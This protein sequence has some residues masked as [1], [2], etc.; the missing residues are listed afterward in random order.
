MRSDL[1]ILGVFLLLGGCVAYEAMVWSECLD[2]NSLFYC[3][4]VLSR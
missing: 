2:K 4:R 1:L 3:V